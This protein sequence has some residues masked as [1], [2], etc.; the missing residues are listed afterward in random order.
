MCIGGAKKILYL[1]VR[2]KIPQNCLNIAA[3]HDFNVKFPDRKFPKKVHVK[4]GLFA[5]NK[6]NCEYNSKFDFENSMNAKF[7]HQ[8]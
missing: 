3:R 6:R 4:L 2:H 8:I 7:M 5:E 1:K